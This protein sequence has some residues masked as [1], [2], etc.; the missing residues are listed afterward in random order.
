MLKLQQAVRP[1]EVNRTCQSFVSF[2]KTSSVRMYR[3][4]FSVLIGSVILGRSQLLGYTFG[5]TGITDKKVKEDRES[6]RALQA[7]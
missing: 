3:V 4:T 6:K 2:V 5:W 7:I 1:G